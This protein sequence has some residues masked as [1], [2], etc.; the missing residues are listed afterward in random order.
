MRRFILLLLT[1]LLSGCIVIDDR[2]N[3]IP[4][5]D[6]SNWVEHETIV[7]GYS[8]RYKIPTSDEYPGRRQEQDGVMN[9]Y[10]RYFDKSYAVLFAATFDRIYETPQ[11]DVVLSKVFSSQPITNDDELSNCLFKDYRIRYYRS[12]K[13]N[14]NGISWLKVESFVDKKATKIAT[15]ICAVKLDNKL[16]LYI[17]S[18]YRLNLGNQR[19]DWD[20]LDWA[21]SSEWISRRRKIF[22]EVVKSIHWSK[23]E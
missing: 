7:D 23:I 16:S 20:N 14:Y 22:D 9:F 4:H 17:H 21:N 6:S 5:F 2:T 15:D 10:K 1:A 19:I 8:V 11:F 13:F 12:S 3:T 18:G